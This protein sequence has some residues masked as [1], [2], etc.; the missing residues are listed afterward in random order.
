MSKA[1]AGTPRDEDGLALELR[2]AAGSAEIL[3]LRIGGGEG[4]HGSE[5]W[6]RMWSHWFG[7]VEAARAVFDVMILLPA[8]WA[9][10]A[11]TAE[12]LGPAIVDGMIE[13]E[14]LGAASDTTAPGRRRSRVDSRNG[15]PGSNRSEGAI[16]V[17]MLPG[18]G[19]PKIVATCDDR[20]FMV[21]GS[22]T[23]AQVQRIWDW[24]RWQKDS[25]PTWYR[26]FK[27]QGTAALVRMILFGMLAAE[28][29]VDTLAASTDP[30]RPLRYWTPS[31]AD[32]RDE[33]DAPV[34]PS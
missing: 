29:N 8:K 28:Q 6:I 17:R 30:Q 2:E 3:I 4:P 20:T 14:V 31:D 19:G 22:S 25:Y 15:S 16:Q 23:A 10:W 13:A 21:L 26:I 9:T 33:G 34:E 11:R 32:D 24:A 12:L 1:N 5:F 7:S 27:R 18:E